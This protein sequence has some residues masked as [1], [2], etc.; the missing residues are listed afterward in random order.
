MMGLAKKIPNG[1]GDKTQNSYKL[2][3]SPP[4]TVSIFWKIIW[5]YKIT[6]W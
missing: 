2:S 6:E 5:A 4:D 1:S 3:E